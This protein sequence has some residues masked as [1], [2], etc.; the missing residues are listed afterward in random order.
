MTILTMILQ[1]FLGVAFV[2]SGG[3]K[4]VSGNTEPKKNFAKMRLP[5]WW[6]APIGLLEVL[7]GFGLL[8]GFVFPVLVTIAALV[9]ACT[10]FGA[11]IAHVIQ[12]RP[13]NG[14]PALVLLVIAGFILTSSW[15]QLALFGGVP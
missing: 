12:D 2:G 14:Y 8:L 10:M 5:N 6:L 4:V 13:F 1:A 7:T 9:A 3:L 11:T 15:Y